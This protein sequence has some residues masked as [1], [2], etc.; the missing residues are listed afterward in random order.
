MKLKFTLLALMFWAAASAQDAGVV[1]VSGAYLHCRPD[2]EASIETQEL[3]GETVQILE[4]K[5]LWLKVRCSQPY[6]GWA[7]SK[8]IAPMDEKALEEWQKAPK[9]I[10]TAMHGRVFSSPNPTSEVICNLVAGDVVRKAERDGKAV[11]VRGWTRI[12]LP[13]GRSGWVHGEGMEDKGT[14]EKRCLSFSRDER[15]SSAV[16]WAEKTLGTPYLWG[17]MT[18]GGF[19]CSGLTRFAYLMAGTR[20]PRNASQQIKC[21][22]RIP[23]PADDEGKLDL[24]YLK[25]G[26]LIFFGR[27]KDEGGSPADTLCHP[28]VSHVGLYLGGGRMIHSSHLVRVNSLV[29]GDADCYESL[30]LLVGACR[31]VE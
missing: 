7:S 13:D 12:V 14:W 15:V 29:R 2:F 26:D 27:F 30:H 19:D 25:A 8:W 11:R 4:R 23:I 6:E 17:G 31:I 3:M 28:A 9:Y 20:L 18:T 10:F 1:N 16:N 24:S 5:G 22:R 21:G